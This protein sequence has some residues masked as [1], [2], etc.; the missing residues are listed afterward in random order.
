[1]PTKPPTHTTIRAQT[2][3]PAP[4]WKWDAIDER[5]AR[6]ALAIARLRGYAVRTMDSWRMGRDAGQATNTRADKA[7][8]DRP[9]ARRQS[10]RSP[11][12]VRGKVA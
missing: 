5:S 11:Q 4:G 7:G 9:R 12:R 1:M 3:Q 6:E 8:Y 10:E 2:G